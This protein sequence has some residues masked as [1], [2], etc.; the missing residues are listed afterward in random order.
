M[1]VNK[2]SCQ[3]SIYS[4]SL[5]RLSIQFFLKRTHFK[6]FFKIIIWLQVPLRCPQSQ[7]LDVGKV[8]YFWPKMI[9]W[10]MLDDKLSIQEWRWM[11]SCQ[12]ILN[13]CIFCQY[14]CTSKELAIYQK[15]APKSVIDFL[16]DFKGWLIFFVRTTHISQSG[17]S[18]KDSQK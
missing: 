4:K 18:D 13:P 3:Q 9:I 14:K 5:L 16:N 17:W 7:P 11:E 1:T 6:I 8:G 15:W 2:E 10:D 12:F